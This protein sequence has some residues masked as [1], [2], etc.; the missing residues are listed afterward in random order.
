MVS[1]HEELLVS[2]IQSL[3]TQGYRVIRLD[4]RIVPDAIAIKNSEVIA[5]EADTSPTKVWL[6]KRKF[7]S[8]KSQY[9][10][11]IIVTK[12]YNSYY[13]TPK[14]YYRV[15]E[16]YNSGDYSFREVK[17]KVMKEFELKTLAIST[18]HD[19]VKRRKIPPT[20]R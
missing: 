16:L 9:D 14:V 20:V 12:P 5:I 10:A 13:H 8:E 17:E 19:W 4:R 2:A 15:L 18:I 7:E 3:E 6:T 11:E 1:L